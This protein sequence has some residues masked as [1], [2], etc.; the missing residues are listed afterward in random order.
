MKLRILATAL[1]LA[2]VTAAPASAMI[3][4]QSLDGV[5]S[6]A[7]ANGNVHGIINGDTVTIFG[8]VESAYDAN[9]AKQAALNIEGVNKVINRISTDR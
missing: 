1:V 8:I 6:S 2:A 7:M 3:S 5:L 9:K 4:R